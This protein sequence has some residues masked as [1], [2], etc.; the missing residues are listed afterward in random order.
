M[1]HG[2]MIEKGE[3]VKIIQK[4]DVTVF[5]LARL[6]G[7]GFYSLQRFLFEDKAGI[8]LST[9]KKLRAAIDKINA[10]TQAVSGPPG[11]EA[12]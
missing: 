9:A 8:T 7:V 2:T 10:D 4:G 11:S 1:N 3:L 6:A 12:V 5:G